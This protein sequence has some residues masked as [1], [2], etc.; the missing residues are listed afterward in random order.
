ME[1]MY[2]LRHLEEKKENIILNYVVPISGAVI[3]IGLNLTPAVLFYELKTN[4]K[5]LSDIP[6]FMFISNV[7]NCTIN[8]AFS[9]ILE[10][11]IM[12]ISNIICTSLTV[13]FSSIYLWYY[14]EKKLNLFILYIFIA[15]NITLETLYASTQS[16][17]DFTGETSF[18][19]I[20]IANLIIGWFQVFLGIINSGAPGQKIFTV[21]QTGNYHLIPI[22]TTCFQCLCS[23]FWGIYGI[24]IGEIKTFIPNALGVILTIAQISV[25]FFN[26]SKYKDKKFDEDN[27]DNEE[28]KKVSTS[29]IDNKDNE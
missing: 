4:K 22:V 7:F 1:I 14:S 11:T 21:I 3:A 18:K 25:Y 23:A 27:S 9:I 17:R 29:L 6:E 10:D 5:K 12:K 2:T 20:P 24:V 15:Y 19:K 8:L 28:E 16:F 26:Y 13:M